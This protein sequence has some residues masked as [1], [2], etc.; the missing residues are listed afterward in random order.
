MSTTY[1]LQVSGGTPLCG[2]VLLLNFNYRIARK[3][4]TIAGVLLGAVAVVGV[5]TFKGVQ[6]VSKTDLGE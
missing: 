5:R 6:R 1:G 2:N 3:K 4:Q